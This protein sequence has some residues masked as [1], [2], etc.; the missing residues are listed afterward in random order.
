MKYSLEFT[1]CLKGVYITYNP[2]FTE[3]DNFAGV[4][5]EIPRITDGFKTEVRLKKQIAFGIVSTPQTHK[6]LLIEIL[7]KHINE[8]Y[9][10]VLIPEITIEK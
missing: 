3:D 1:T 4:R 10:K 8:F 5:I 7:R 2:S 6:D 9:D